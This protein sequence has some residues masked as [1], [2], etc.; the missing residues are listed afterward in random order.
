MN[1]QGVGKLSRNMVTHQIQVKFKK[2]DSSAMFVYH[3]GITQI[4]H[5]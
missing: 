4:C 5:S 1:Y 3:I 2:R